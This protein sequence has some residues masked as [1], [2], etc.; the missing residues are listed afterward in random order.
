MTGASRPLIFTSL[1]L[2]SL[3]L[4]AC[5]H[6]RARPIEQRTL[7]GNHVVEYEGAP[8]KLDPLPPANVPQHPYMAENGRSAM[9]VDSFCSNTYDTR[10]VKGVD[11]KVISDSMGVIGGECST[12][13]F[14]KQGRVLALC[15]RKSRPALRLIDPASLRE[16]A[17]YKLP[18]RNVRSLHVRKAMGDTG[19]GAYF[20]VDHEDRAV[21]GTSAD[22]IQVVSV[23]VNARG[24]EHF[25]VDESMDV[26][27]ALQHEGH[28]DHMTAVMP[29][30]QGH[31]WF[32][33]RYGTVGVV[34]PGIAPKFLHLPGEQIEN[35]FSVGPDGVYIVSDHALYRMERGPHGAPHVVWRVPYDRG[36]HRKVGQINQGSGTT[37]SLLGDK[38]VAIADN[39]E[40]RMH[41]LVYAR[42]ERDGARPICQV[43]VFEPNRSATENSLIAYG[44]SLIVENN[45]GYDLFLTM[46]HDRTSA[47]G[48][49]RVDIR[50]DESGCDV[51]WSVDEIS[52]TV[53]PKMS[54]KTGL[55]YLYTKAPASYRDT[56]E[57]Y[58]TALDF[59]TGKPV[60]RVLTGTGMLFDNNWAELALAPDGKAFVGVLNG[61]L[62]VSDR[63]K[64]R[65]TSR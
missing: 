40:P 20:Y 19:G 14:D 60:F 2:C 46:R 16:L 26:S 54:T 62:R 28:S 45:F 64:P 41:V 23:R 61:F 57:F 10:G 13:N 58:L 59:Q 49:A 51:R 12:L 25:H 36:T 31:Y 7:M 6:R 8:S 38:Y 15:V 29:D 32:A 52:Q 11:P 18:R 17:V 44:N 27:E 65:Y 24:R 43:P 47:P 5:S 55:V 9:H 56:E 33:G 35:S 50:P 1:M 53:V 39:A 34:D 42:D 4:A 3:G 37:P 48:V 22:E 63:T 21:M 30:W